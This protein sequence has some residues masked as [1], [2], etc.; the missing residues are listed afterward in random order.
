MGKKERVIL[1]KGDA[2]QWYEQ[3]IFIVNQNTA[4]ENIPLD[5]V[6]EAEKIINNHVRNKY[7]KGSSNVGIA[8]APA[9]AA[10][11]KPAIA[12]KPAKRKA[13][14]FDI[15]LNTIMGLGCVIIAAFLLWGIFA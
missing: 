15:V 3:A 12:K 5:F 14:N 8:Y 4:P 9:P 13:N 10:V 1:I 7:N 11:H 6:A 2:S